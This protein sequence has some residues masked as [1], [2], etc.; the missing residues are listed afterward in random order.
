MIMKISQS[1][2]SHA[3]TSQP[4]QKMIL[5]NNKMVVIPQQSRDGNTKEW[6]RVKFRAKKVFQNIVWHSQPLETLQETL[7]ERLLTT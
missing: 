4:S 7:P 1:M 5:Y 2:Q 3:M 6:A